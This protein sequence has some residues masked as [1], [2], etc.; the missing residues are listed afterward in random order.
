M[1]I[2]DNRKI[3]FGDGGNSR[4]DF[5][6]GYN[7]STDELELA[8]GFGA[9]TADVFFTTGGKL[10]FNVSGGSTCLQF[11][12]ADNSSFTVMSIQ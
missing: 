1:H 10:G 7:S 9:D 2:G 4:P 11:E 6:L 12:D 8:C 5:Q 3:G